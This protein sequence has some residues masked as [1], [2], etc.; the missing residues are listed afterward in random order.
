MNIIFG[1]PS[2]FLEIAV[3][4]FIEKRR[5]NW[6]N[7]TCAKTSGTVTKDKEKIVDQWVPSYYPRN[8]FGMHFGS[9]SLLVSKV[10][11]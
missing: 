7:L 5:G 9:S 4:L 2:T 11:F 6:P 1:R 8:H 3:H 10:L